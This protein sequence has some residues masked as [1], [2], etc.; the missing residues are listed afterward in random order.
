MKNQTIKIF[1]LLFLVFACTNYFEYH[2]GAIIRGDKNRKALAL[3]FTGDEFADGGQHIRSTLSRYNIRAAFFLT[4]NFYRN[5]D[6]KELISALHEDGHYLGAHS[7]KHLL[8]CSWDNRDSLLV[9]KEKFLTDLDSNYS[10]MR[11]FGIQ[12][13]DARFFLP[14]YEWYNLKISQWCQETG[15]T[16]VNFTPGTKSHTDWTHPEIGKGYVSREYIYRNILDFEKKET[17]GLNG[18]ILLLHIGSDPRR[19]DKFHTK[20][21]DLIDDLIIKGYRFKRIDALLKIE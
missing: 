15:I 13:S 7:D 19:P 18:F 14:P 4:G 2:H 9:S 20:L 3:V 12:K 10:A 11:N 21:A 8:Y 1:V 6:F 5:P 16:L 17:F